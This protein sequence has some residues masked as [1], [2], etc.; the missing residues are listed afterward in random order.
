MSEERGHQCTFTAN[1][2]WGMFHLNSSCTADVE[3]HHSVI[4]AAN[5]TD[6]FLSADNEALITEFKSA[7]AIFALKEREACV[8][9][10]FYPL[11]INENSRSL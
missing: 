6:Y 11:R 7:A 1:I 5:F 8:Y 3:K 9:P 4:K 2:Q 10:L